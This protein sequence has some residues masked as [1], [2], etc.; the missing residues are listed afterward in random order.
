MVEAGMLEVVAG[1]TVF[2]QKYIKKVN[3]GD[4]PLFS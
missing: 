4:Q 1:K 3:E 2:Q